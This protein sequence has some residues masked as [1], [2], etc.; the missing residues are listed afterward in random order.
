MLQ[1]PVWKANGSS[2]APQ[3][4]CV[5]LQ[6]LPWASSRP[7]PTALRAGNRNPPIGKAF[8]L[9][10]GPVY[11]GVAVLPNG[12]ERPLPQA[13]ASAQRHTPFAVVPVVGAGGV[14]GDVVREQLRC[15]CGRS[16]RD[17]SRGSSTAPARS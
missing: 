7:P 5:Q 15:V 10:T 17:R 12:P 3:L 8:W 6:L 11:G 1:P 13:S 4:F 9:I 14:A 2:L 16:C